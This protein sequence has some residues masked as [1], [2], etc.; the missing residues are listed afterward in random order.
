MRLKNIEALVDGA[1]EITI[2]RIGPIPCA[3][4]ASDDDQQYAMLVRRP[5]ESL[6]ALLKRLDHALERA[7]EHDEFT[8]EI[9]G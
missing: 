7:W 5:R 3:A 1:G 6:E 8:D 9:N 2:G 4:T